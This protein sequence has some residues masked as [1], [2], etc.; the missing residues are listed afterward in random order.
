VQGVQ[1]HPQKFRFGKNPGKIRG[2]LG[3]ISENLQKILKIKSC[4]QPALKKIGAQNRTQSFFGGHFFG[5]FRASLGEFGKKSFA[6]SK[7][8]LFLHLCAK[9]R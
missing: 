7:I 5:A 9:H 3:K 4:A 6:P 1:A 2:I 8:C